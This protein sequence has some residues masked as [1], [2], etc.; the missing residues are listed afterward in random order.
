MLLSKIYKEAMDIKID[1]RAIIDIFA[2]RGKFFKTFKKEILP[3]P[4]FIDK[5]L[6]DTK[7]APKRKEVRNKM[8]KQAK[9]CR[10]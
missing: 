4:Y 3:C 7:V 10:A 9:A 8:E 1:G 2:E 5:M 6:T